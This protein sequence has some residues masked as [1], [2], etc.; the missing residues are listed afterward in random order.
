MIVV[1]APALLHPL[2]VALDE[3][4]IIKIVNLVKANENAA[5]NEKAV[6]VKREDFGTAF[7][8][9]RVAFIAAYVDMRIIVSLSEILVAD[10]VYFDLAEKT[11]NKADLM[12]L[13]PVAKT[14]IHGSIAFCND[15]AG[16]RSK[17]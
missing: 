1:P 3:V 11:K 5:E 2:L 8:R 14:V 7:R 9:R 17:V 10:L 13:R 4:L 12:V 16:K 15:N 6:A